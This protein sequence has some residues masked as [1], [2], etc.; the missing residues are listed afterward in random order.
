[1]TTRTTPVD[2]SGLASGVVA[3]AAGHYHTSALT[4]TGPVKCWGYNIHGQ[5]GDG[6]TTLRYTPVDV[7]ELTNGAALVA[8][9]D[10]TCALTSGGAVKCWGDNSSNQL[11]DGTTASSLVPVEVSGLASGVVA[12][13]AGSAHT[14]AVMSG[15]A[16][17]CWGANRSGQ[18]G[19]G[20]WSWSP[21]TTSYVSGLASGATA[22][23]V[24]A[25]HTCVLTSGGIAECW[26]NNWSGQLGDGTTASKYT[27]VG[28]SG[29]TSGVT[30]LAAGWSHTCAV[31]SE[32]RGQMLGRQPIRAVGRRHD[33]G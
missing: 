17:K 8:G 24:G 32:G 20:T 9:W 14:C 25:V 5:L 3:V 26:G 29:L 22:L 6:T 33:N 15:G 30:A 28:V 18:L 4:V 7:S 27:P 10:H 12:L 31:T 19:R 13:A 2:V 11:G 21:A 1:M 23:A 16:L